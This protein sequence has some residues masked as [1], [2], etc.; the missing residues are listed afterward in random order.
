MEH[1]LCTRARLYALSLILMTLV[2]GG[3]SLSMAQETKVPT[4]VTN[5][6][7]WL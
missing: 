7:V 5:R 6:A 1:L 2:A 4:H 3:C